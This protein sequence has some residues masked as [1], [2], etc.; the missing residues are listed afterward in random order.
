MA[1]NTT[2]NGKMTNDVEKDNFFTMMAPFLKGNG[3][4]TKLMVKV[5]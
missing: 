4:M 5:K 3:V 2:A 1:I